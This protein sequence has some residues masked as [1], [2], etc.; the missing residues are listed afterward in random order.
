MSTP[1]DKARLP[2]PDVARGIS[3]IG[4]VALHAT[5]EV[6]GGI[7][8]G[9]ARLNAFIDPL[10][11]PLF[12]LVSGFFALK[13]TRFTAKELFTHRLWYLFVPYILWTPI[14]VLLTEYLHRGRIVGLRE[15]TELLFAAHSMYWFLYMLILFTCV[16]W[17]SRS[18]R[19][20]QQLLIP[21]LIIAVT[22]LLIQLPIPNIHRFLY[23]LPPFLLGAYLRPWITHFAMSAFKPGHLLGAG[24]LA[25][26]A[27][28]IELIEFSAFWEPLQFVGIRL[29]YLPL[30]VIAA[31][32]LSKIPL[33]GTVL[34]SVGQ[35]TLVIYLGHPIGLSLGLLILLPFE[36]F[37]H[38]HFMVGAALG[39]SIL[40]AWVLHRVHQLPG[41]RWLVTPPPISLPLW[42]TRTQSVHLASR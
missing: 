35:H 37:G 39:C 5:I 33:V 13:V 1:S 11:M 36:H 30:A 38:T 41:L 7:D 2:W 31:V 28:Q 4:V 14:W 34:A 6:P 18:W 24:G 32:A 15:L 12:F 16:L 23:Y 19:L 3:I 17:L 29:A 8:T 42:G 40:G 25:V 26:G 27:Y 20:S 9:L 10:R 22:P 21:S